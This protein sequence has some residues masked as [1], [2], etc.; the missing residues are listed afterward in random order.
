LQIFR[1]NVKNSATNQDVL[2]CST[3]PVRRGDEGERKILL[4]PLNMLRVVIPGLTRNPVQS[5]IPASAG[6]T[7][8]IYII[9]DVITFDNM[10]EGRGTTDLSPWGQVR[11]RS[12]PLKWEKKLIMTR[13]R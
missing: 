9:A 7:I 4:R 1:K 13:P 5:W 10:P 6:M 12:S 11:N 2:I 8:L 3:P